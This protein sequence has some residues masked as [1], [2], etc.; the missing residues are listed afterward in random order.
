ML[1]RKNRVQSLK[2]ST[3]DCHDETD[4]RSTIIDGDNIDSQNP[5][6]LVHHPSSTNLRISNYRSCASFR[7]SESPTQTDAG[8]CSRSSSFLTG[9][10]PNDAMVDDCVVGGCQSQV[11][12]WPT[13]KCWTPVENQGRTERNG[14]FVLHKMKD[15]HPTSDCPMTKGNSC[16]QMGCRTP[17]ELSLTMERSS[18]KRHPSAKEGCSLPREHTM[19]RELLTPKECSTPLSHHDPIF[20]QKRNPFLRR[21]ADDAQHGRSSSKV[22]VRT[23]S[24]EM[25]RVQNFSKDR[26]TDC[27]FVHCTSQSARIRSSTQFGAENTSERAAKI[28]QRKSSASEGLM[29]SQLFFDKAPR[30]HPSILFTEASTCCSISTDLNLPSSS[31]YGKYDN[32]SLSSADIDSCSCTSTREDQIKS[33]WLLPPS[34][35]MAVQRS[36]IDPKQLQ[37]GDRPNSMKSFFQNATLYPSK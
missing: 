31:I 9:K 35:E 32:V 36:S 20:I 33:Q 4:V 3:P 25:D 13:I 24:F 1:R 8:S 7:G 5:Y 26:D 27:T 30:E 18:A 23:K 17:R 37:K 16:S 19:P 6:I 28:D 22:S 14:P 11:K 2:Q 10:P 12:K 21:I 15:E 29:R 34:W